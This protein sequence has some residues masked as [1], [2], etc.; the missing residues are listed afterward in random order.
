MQGGRDGKESA[1]RNTVRSVRYPLTLPL[2]IE[3][4]IKKGIDSPI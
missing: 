1:E 4:A 3:V 2:L